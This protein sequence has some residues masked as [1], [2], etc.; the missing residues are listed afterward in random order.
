MFVD[1]FTDATF[2]DVRDVEIQ[3]RGSS[4]GRGFDV[5]PDGFF[6]PVPSPQFGIYANSKGFEFRDG[7]VDAFVDS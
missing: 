6:N 3:S 2:D 7:L 4:V 1:R 5:L